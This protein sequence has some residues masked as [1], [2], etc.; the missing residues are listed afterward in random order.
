[1]GACD[2]DI[3]IYLSEYDSYVCMTTGRVIELHVDCQIA[4]CEDGGVTET[5]GAPAGRASFFELSPLLLLSAVLLS[6]L[7]LP[8]MS[9]DEI[10]KRAHQYTC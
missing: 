10:L 2:I 4:R 7:G 6:G 8:L 5:S 1:M 9:L 3:S